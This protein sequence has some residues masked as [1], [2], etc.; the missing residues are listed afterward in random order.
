MGV[1]VKIKNIRFI[2]FCVK[3]IN[4]QV[5]SEGI[6]CTYKNNKYSNIKLDLLNPE[7]ILDKGYSIVYKDN[8]VVKDVFSLKENDNINI[9][10][11]NGNI[12]ANVKGVDKR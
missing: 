3:R 9:I 8:K 11:K 10:A 2:A 7:N 1:V 4:G 5:F 6:K 12:T